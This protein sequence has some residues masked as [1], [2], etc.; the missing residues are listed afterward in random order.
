MFNTILG[1]I[2]NINLQYF[3][4]SGERCFFLSKERNKQF[5]S[6]YEDRRNIG[7]IIFEGLRTKGY[8]LTD[9]HTLELF[10]NL[11]D[12]IGILFNTRIVDRDT[13]LLRKVYSS[14]IIGEYN[15]YSIGIIDN[16]L[17]VDGNIIYHSPKGINQKIPF[18]IDLNNIR[19][20]VLLNPKNIREE[21]IMKSLLNCECNAVVGY[22]GN[23]NDRN[24]KKHENIIRALQE[25]TNAE[26]IS[27]LSTNNSYAYILTK[28][29]IR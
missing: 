12:S 13:T 27:G 6:F 1:E 8:D 28:N 23:L 7:R 10:A 18:P 5:I 22:Y 15:S 3:K 26:L 25:K 29:R 11:Y 24:I 2:L 14:N 20:Y 4:E 9:K 19:K 17:Y 21:R 16:K